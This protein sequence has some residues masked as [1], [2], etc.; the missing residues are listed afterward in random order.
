MLGSRAGAAC[1][2]PAPGI[3]APKGII[4]CIICCMSPV[5]GFA[6]ACCMA[7][8]C[9]MYVCSIAFIS[10]LLP[11]PCPPGLPGAPAVEAIAGLFQFADGT[12][13]VFNTAPG[14]LGLFQAVCTLPAAV[15]EAVNK[16]AVP[17]PPVALLATLAA[18][19]AWFC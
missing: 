1:C 7:I 14:L 6:C 15:G 4:D 13:R 10:G 5:I 9:D 8:C 18:G 17:E 12:C 2:A 11:I 19:T 16:A 3:T